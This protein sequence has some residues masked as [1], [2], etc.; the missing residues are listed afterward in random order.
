MA[1]GLATVVVQEKCSLYKPDS[2][3]MQQDKSLVKDLATV[4]VQWK[5]VAI[6]KPGNS[7]VQR[8]GVAICRPGNS[9]MQQKSLAKDLA[10]LGVPTN[11]Y[12]Y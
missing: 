9:G 2:S 12:I 8:K 4:A 3:G 1:T 11:K 6:C 5:G 10:T 7:G